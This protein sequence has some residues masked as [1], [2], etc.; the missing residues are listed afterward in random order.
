MMN[1][2]KPVDRFGIPY[3]NWW[4]EALHGVARAGHATSFPQAIGM[5]AT[6]DPALQEKT[7][8]YVSDEARAKY[9]AVRKKDKFVMYNGLTF[10]T[11]NINIFRDPRWG[12]GQETYGEDP[13][14]TSVMGMATVRGLQGND[15]KYL[16]AHACAKHFA[17]HSGPEKDRHSF[18]VTVSGRDLWETYLPAF[19][20]L[21]TKANVKEVMGAYHSYDGD[22]CC[23]S[24]LLL[25]EILHKKWGYDG[26]VVSDCG[27]IED[28]YKKDAHAK[29]PDAASASAAAV[30]AGT[31]IE[32]GGT[33]SSLVEAVSRNLIDEGTI[34]A[35]VR[36]ILKGRFELGMFDPDSMVPW[37]SITE[38]VIESNEHKAHAL[39][40]ARESV[41]M[42]KNNGVLPASPS[43]IKKIAV[44]GPNADDPTMMLANYNGFP[45]HVTT[46]LEGIRAAYPNAEVTYERG[47]DIVEGWRYVQPAQERTKTKF[48]VDEVVFSDMSAAEKGRFF[49][50]MAKEASEVD[51]S[52]DP[53]PMSSDNY[54]KE[55]LSKLARRSADADLIIFVGGLSANIEGEE[56]KDMTFDGF[57]GGDRTKIELPEVQSKVLKALHSTGK[58]VV[59]VLCTGS[60]VALSQNEKDY[61]ALLC[62]WYGGQAGGT[63]VGEIL[64]GKV[65]PSGK[66]P[67]TFYASTS[68]LPDFSSYDMKGRTYRYMKESPLYPLGYGLSYASFEYGR[69]SLSSSRIKAGEKVTVNVSV[70]NLSRIAAD[71]IVE[72]YVRRLGDS[73]APFK[74]L[75]GFQRVNILPGQTR[76]VSITLDADAFKYYD[77]K[78]DGLVVKPGNYQI[79]VGGSSADSS[80][81]KMN[82]TVL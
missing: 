63:A 8:S 10:W 52:K 27:A 6:F 20:A 65:S 64:S 31:C 17:V 19:E 80:L 42:L 30:K 61:D 82:L 81:K 26:I 22:P 32:C 76:F 51:T 44:V 36:K 3:Y 23:E 56:M 57:D 58:P 33:Y 14:L 15:S 35:A 41:V 59:F 45:E 78:E 48:Q 12:R 69:S 18:D 24:D 73:K 43:T 68:Q 79:M 21:V 34:D 50:Q 5:A 47:C 11:P 70:T 2:N 72:V 37:S 62:A 13:Y 67:V 46:I 39:K 71:E 60:A 29:Y 16:K 9:N 28:F 54:T 1:G 49:A 4:N 77:Q 40:V 25:D 53:K 75:K 38:S 7:F 66:L 55:S 74:S